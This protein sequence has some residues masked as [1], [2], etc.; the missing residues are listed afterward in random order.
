MEDE[1]IIQHYPGVEVR[2]EVTPMFEE[3]DVVLSALKQ[4][5]SQE[6]INIG[7]YQD[8]RSAYLRGLLPPSD[9]P[10]IAA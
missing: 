10:D 1:P 8:R 2:L 9:P 4:M 7:E 6:V 3:K 5:L